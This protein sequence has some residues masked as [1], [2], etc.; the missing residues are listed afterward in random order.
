MEVTDLLFRLILLFL[1]GIVAFILVD[2]LTVHKKFELDEKVLYSLILGLFSYLLYT[3]GL[4]AFQSLGWADISR[5]PS[6][7]SAVSNTSTPIDFW[8]IAVCIPVSVVTGFSV[9]YAISHRWVFRLGKFL[10]VTQKHG[11]PGALE[12]LINSNAQWVVIRDAERDLMYYGKILLWSNPDERDEICL[13]EVKVYR[14]S[15]G[16]F[17]YDTPTLLVMADWSKLSFEFPAI[18]KNLNAKRNGKK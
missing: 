16:N 3:L 13:T 18:T 5:N 7:F 12:Y 2:K 8:E 17:L 10:R 4:I 15:T 9:S 6:F 1:P 11:S 14:N